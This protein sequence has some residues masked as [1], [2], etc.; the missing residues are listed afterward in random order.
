MPKRK[1]KS[2][3]TQPVDAA[4]A[5]EP[6]LPET[7]PLQ[8]RYYGDVVLRQRAAT[9]EQISE[10]ELQLAD[11]MFQTL[12]AIGNGI[13]L[14]AT[15]VGIL[16]RL[17]V[18]VLGEQ[19]E[20]SH[21]PV[22]LFNPEI[23]SVTGEAVAEEGCLSI[24]GVTADVKRPEQIVVEAVNLKNKQ[25]RIEADGLLARVLQHEIDHLNGV[26]FIDRISGVKRQMLNPALQL[27]QQ[28]DRPSA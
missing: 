9:V 18:I 19:D 17:I 10:A 13:G 4:L 25:V 22:A 27:L 7:V 8:M 28:A 3:N 15:Q 26:L 12:Y 16:K 6:C 11:E 23:L 24:P 14:A 5:D 20:E 2:K 1:R 21:E